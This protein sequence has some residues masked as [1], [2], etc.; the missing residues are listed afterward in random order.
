MWKCKICTSLREWNEIEQY[1]AGRTDGFKQKS[2]VIFRPADMQL[3]RDTAEGSRAQLQRRLQKWSSF[4]RLS[5]RQSL[6]FKSFKNKKMTAAP[7]HRYICLCAYAEIS[8]NIDLEAWTGQ[9]DGQTQRQTSC[10]LIVHLTDRYSS[11]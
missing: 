3:V 2:R 4:F 6:V 11:F 10:D 1:N 5:G 9:T 7:Y 8:P